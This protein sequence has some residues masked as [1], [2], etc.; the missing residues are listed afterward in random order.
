MINDFEKMNWSAWKKMPS[1][2]NCREITGPIKS[3]VYQLKNL[4]T[5]EYI[6]FG[7][8]ITCQK[9]MKSLFPK[10]YGTGTRN[11]ENK[12][13]Y[14]FHNWQRLIYRTIATKS[15]DEAKQIE[16]ILKKSKIHLFN[17]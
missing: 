10:P 5:G 15:K 1:P 14:V 3:G 13:I 9:R 7:I 11:N 6:L 4:K 12:R 17:T 8:S 16:D 2:T